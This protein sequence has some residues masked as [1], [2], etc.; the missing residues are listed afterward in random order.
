MTETGLPDGV[1]PEPAE[2]PSA[3]PPAKNFTA[4]TMVFETS[5]LY[6]AVQKAARISPT[7]GDGFDKAGGIFFDVDPTARTCVI[8]ATD[9]D[10]TY[11]QEVPVLEGSGGKNAWRIPARQLV[12]LLANLPQAEGAA[13]HVIDTGQGDST[14]RISAGKTFASLYMMSTDVFPRNAFQWELG[15]L[16]NA[17][18]LSNKVERVSWA[19]DH[20]SKDSP[21]AGVHIDGKFLVGARKDAM[22][23]VPCEVTLDRAVTV[24][25]NTLAALLKGASE[26]KIRATERRCQLQLDSRTKTTSSLIEGN[27]P[28]VMRVQRT[29]FMGT[30][31]VRK[32]SFLETLERMQAM[33]KTEKL[34]RLTISIEPNA[35]IQSMVFDLQVPNQSR[36]RDEID[37]ETTYSGPDFVIQFTPRVL[38]D[39]VTHVRG[40]N[41]TFSWG[42]ADPEKPHDLMSVEIA[43][44]GGY[45]CYAMPRKPR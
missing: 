2:E 34:P 8:R 11:E 18:D 32:T 31:T 7:K 6:D 10:V 17:A 27:Y 45:K 28:D 9:L 20:K 40:D 14:I 39:A 30:A 26:C 15:V 12:D 35:L 37:I 41:F 4:T 25:L 38:V 33:S 16:S 13:V 24:P 3:P 22:V 36:I 19:C 5:L 1:A 21:L 43:D 44:E 29:D 42:S 23:W